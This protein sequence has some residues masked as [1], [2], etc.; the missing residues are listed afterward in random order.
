MLGENVRERGGY[1]DN[2]FVSWDKRYRKMFH[3][4][5][6]TLYFWTFFADHLHLETVYAPRNRAH[7][8]VHPVKPHFMQNEFEMWFKT[9][10]AIDIIPQ[11]WILHKYL[12]SCYPFELFLWSQCIASLSCVETSPKQSRK[13]P[14]QRL[15]FLWKAFRYLIK[16]LLSYKI[17]PLQKYSMVRW[18]QCVLNK[19]HFCLPDAI[20]SAAG[21]L[22]SCLD[23]SFIFWQIPVSL[24]PSPSTASLCLIHFVFHHSTFFQADLTH[25]FPVF[26]FLVHLKLKYRCFT[27]PVTRPPYIP[28]S[29][30]WEDAF[31]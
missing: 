11:C 29:M 10:T 26:L 22:E 16:Y 12:S 23:C 3:S 15:L 17:P 13:P 31:C 28:Y 1:S 19:Q 14:I 2:A 5:R 24:C 30:P 27:V 25:C 8:L 21:P 6:C 4:P 18:C 9:S 20:S 7:R